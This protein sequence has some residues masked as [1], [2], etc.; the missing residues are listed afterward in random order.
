MKK[1][2]ALLLAF[3]MLFTFTACKSNNAEKETTISTK[4]ETTT[5]EEDETQLPGDN[6]EL[7]CVEILT[8]TWGSWKGE[9]FAA[10]GGDVSNPIEDAPGEYNI[11]DENFSS[12]LVFPEDKMSKI[13]EAASLAHAMNANTFT[14]GAF[15]VK[16]YD[17]FA[18][19]YDIKQTAHSH[20]WMCGI[21][22]RFVV[23]VVG[24]Y[25]VSFF[26]AQDFVDNFENAL[27]V[28]YDGAVLAADEI[29]I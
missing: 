6:A 11:K 17:P 22:E 25:V 10:L 18:L 8:T 29:I 5:K 15:H 20:H 28:N 14:A 23:F 24:D 16:G 7:G 4:S 12:T 27:L 13:D 9:K 1:Y 3:A 19:A 26:G 21:P 2:L